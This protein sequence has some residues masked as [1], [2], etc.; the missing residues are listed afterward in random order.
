LD[1]IQQ[2]NGHPNHVGDHAVIGIVTVSDRASAGEY[3]DEG[4]PAVLS[5][6][7]EGIASPLT[8]H[9]RCVPDDKSLIE[10]TLIEMVDELGCHVLVTTGGTGPAQRDVTPE[11]TE[12]VC[13]KILPGFGEQMRAISLQYVPT[14]ILSR[15][16]GGIRGNC[17][18]FN[19]PGR[20]K[21]IRETI[22]EIW[23]AVP[24]CVD[25]LEGPYI[26]TVDNVCNAF[27]PKSARRK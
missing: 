8:V 16:L 3:E 4:G 20:P 27:R 11:A 26:D 18:L 14:A 21:S 25:L 13:E 10:K 9:Y 12:K 15:Q 23:K 17:L 5:F 1:L 24:Y 19:L 2:L 7:D 6:L 22:D